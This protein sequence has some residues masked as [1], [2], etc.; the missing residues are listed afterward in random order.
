MRVDLSKQKML[1]ANKA[2]LVAKLLQQL[3]HCAL[4]LQQI[5]Q[6][7]VLVYNQTTA[8]VCKA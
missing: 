5:E 6:A 3:L 7:N 1:V 2:A 8:R 4:K